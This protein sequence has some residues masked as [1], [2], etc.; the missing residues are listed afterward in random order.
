MIHRAL[1][2]LLPLSLLAC[3]GA[4]PEPAPPSLLS[5]AS[6]GSSSSSFS[7]PSSPS[8]PQHNAHGDLIV[9]P[10]LACVS[11]VLR[12]EVLDAKAGLDLLQRASSAIAKRFEMA[13]AGAARTKMLGAVVNGVSHSKLSSTDG[14]PT[15]VVTADGSIEASMD[16]EA[17]YWA[18]ARLVAALVTAASEKEV[19]AEKGQPEIETAFGSPELKLR[20]PEAFRAEL[21]KRWIARARAFASAAESQAAPL[22]IVNCEPP[23]VITVTPISVEQI[24]LSLP[25]SCRIDAGR[26]ATP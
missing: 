20:D 16:K 17:D 3:G 6:Y 13:T 19:A 23:P 4:Y 15:F 8:V 1:P 10:D 24:A 9:K 2:L 25:V 5:N 14:K 22:A 12:T 18:R 11:F 7:A 26:R 21:E